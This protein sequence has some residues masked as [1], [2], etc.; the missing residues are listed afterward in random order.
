MT[1]TRVI[2]AAAVMEWR[3]ER[4]AGGGEPK[5]IEVGGEFEKNERLT[6][7]APTPTNPRHTFTVHHANQLSHHKHNGPPHQAAVAELATGVQ[8]IKAAVL[9]APV[10]TGAH[11]CARQVEDDSGFDLTAERKKALILEGMTEA[12]KSCPLHSRL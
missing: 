2:F 3:A 7:E 10:A 12:P 11:C 1:M 5:I 6:S 4:E 9:G 8:E